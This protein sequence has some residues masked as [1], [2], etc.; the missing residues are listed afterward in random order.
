MHNLPTTQAIGKIV[1]K[2]KDTGVVTKIERPVCHHFARSVENIP[3][4][5]ESVAEDLNVS[6]PRRS[7]KLGLSYGALW[8]IL[9]L[10]LHL[11][12]YRVQHTQQLK[13]VDNSQRRRHVE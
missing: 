11:H 1:K 2:F 6:I 8:R 7:Q 3:I 12:P 10:D 13:P 9:H 4:I 5:S